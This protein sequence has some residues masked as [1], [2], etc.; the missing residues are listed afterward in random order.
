MNNRIE[1]FFRLLF[2]FT[3]GRRSTGG[4][5]NDNAGSI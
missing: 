2:A 3:V 5:K 4:M 1:S